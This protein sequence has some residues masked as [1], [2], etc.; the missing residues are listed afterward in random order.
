MTFLALDIGTSELKVSVFNAV[1][2]SLAAHRSEVQGIS[3]AGSL[4]QAW[5]EGIKIPSL[6]RLCKAILEFAA[7]HYRTSMPSG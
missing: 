7:T 4:A 6:E 1:G 5:E 2:D 3:A